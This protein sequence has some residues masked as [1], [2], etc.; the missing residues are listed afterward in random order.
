MRKPV[1]FILSTIVLKF[2]RIKW[3]RNFPTWEIPILTTIPSKRDLLYYFRYANHTLL[4]LLN[5]RT[6]HA[7]CIEYDL[8]PRIVLEWA[9]TALALY[10]AADLYDVS[11]TYVAFRGAAEL[12][13]SATY[14]GRFEL[15]D[16][17][18]TIRIIRRIAHHDD[19]SSYDDRMR[20]K[21]ND[22]SIEP[23]FLIY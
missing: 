6:E 21:H 5:V 17:H 15:H 23:S 7:S 12:P 22:Y 4:V 13:Y 3:H 2:Y 19:K 18:N 1:N 9:N 8:L 16:K 11:T 20:K 10:S 14:F